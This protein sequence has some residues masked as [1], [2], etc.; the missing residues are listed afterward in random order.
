[1]PSE[2]Y[3][4]PQGGYFP[5]QYP[6]QPF[7]SPTVVKKQW[8][9]RWWFWLIVILV[10]CLL[11]CGTLAGG[12]LLLFKSLYDSPAA[13]IV[14]SYYTSIEKQN[15]TTAYSFLDPDK[16]TLYGRHLTQGE[17]IQKA[18]VLDVQE[19]KVTSYSLSSVG[20]YF[21]NGVGTADVTVSVTRKEATYPVQVQFLQEPDGWKIVRIDGI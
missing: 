20:V 16:V 4:N 11:A 19:G 13:K 12:F 6:L 7:P 21:S 18:Q 9:K 5:P 3:G 1:M 14:D 15:Y 10:V 17:Y 2:Y 8:W